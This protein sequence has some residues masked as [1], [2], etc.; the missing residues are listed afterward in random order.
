[1]EKLKW[2]LKSYITIALETPLCY[3]NLVY[4][5]VF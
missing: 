1:M 5:D 3:E 4:S 2:N